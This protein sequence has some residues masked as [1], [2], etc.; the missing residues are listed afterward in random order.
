MT[1]DETATGT[2]PLGRELAVLLEGAGRVL[3]LR[4]IFRDFLDVAGLPR[5]LTWHLDPACL[6][7]K[8][9]PEGLRGC[10]AFCAGTVLRELVHHPDGRVQVC[11][12]GHTEVAVPVLLRGRY[13]GIVSAGPMWCGAGAPPRRGLVAPPGPG[14]VTD[15]HRLLQGLARQIA[16]RLERHLDPGARVDRNGRILRFLEAR[17]ARPLRLEDL[18]RHL[19][20][21]ASRCGHLVREVFG[22][23]FPALLRDLRLARAARRLADGDETVAVIARA[24]G[25]DD[26]GYFARLFRRAHGCAPLEYRRRARA[27]A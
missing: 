4:V 22:L 11:P 5:R 25:L 12:F 18:A 8:A 20:L 24:V 1:A 9:D 15:R 19:D 21:S 17:L 3:G 2:S 10:V 26:P 6:A 16:A 7:V 14:W 23:T 13:L 27:L